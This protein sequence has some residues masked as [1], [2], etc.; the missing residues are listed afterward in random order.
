[1]NLLSCL[2]LCS[3]LTLSAAE[4]STGDS[5]P[6]CELIDQNGK[7]CR[8]SQFKGKAVALNFIF[9]RCPLP[10]YCPLLTT[11]FSAAQRE[12]TKDK[13]WHLLSL[14][15]DP[16]HDTPAQLSAYM[17]MHSVDAARWTF[18]TAKAGVVREFGALFGLKAELKNGLI[19][20]N[21]RTVVVDTEGRVQYIF[22]GNAWTTQ[23]LVWE[24][25][26]AMR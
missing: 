2:M 19:D 10:D 6:D 9:T 18:A 17:K 1:M 5:V 21:L 13:N 16:D 15:F 8:L 24:M 22:A 12:L 7:P 23:E 20:H 26:K 4:L 3:A 25:R 11:R 14:S